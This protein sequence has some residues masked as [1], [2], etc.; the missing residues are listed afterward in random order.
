MPANHKI[1]AQ[2][3]E[4]NN[5]SE[6]LRVCGQDARRSARKIIFFPSENYLWPV[7]QRLAFLICQ[8]IDVNLKYRYE[9]E[10]GIETK[11]CSK[12]VV[13]L[14]VNYLEASVVKGSLIPL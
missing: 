12:H 13:I 8:V 4:K 14:H 2:V 5:L 11:F 1:F 3:D 6:H 9:M 7:F 10:L